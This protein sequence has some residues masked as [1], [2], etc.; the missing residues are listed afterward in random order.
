MIWYCLGYESRIE[1][2]RLHFHCQDALCT[3]LCDHSLRLPKRRPGRPARSDMQGDRAV[4]PVCADHLSP[5]RARSRPVH[6]KP[7]RTNR[8][9]TPGVGALQIL[10]GGFA[11]CVPV[12][13]EAG[14]PASVLPLRALAGSY[15]RNFQALEN[16]VPWVSWSV[17]PSK[18]SP[19]NWR[20]R[21]SGPTSIGRK[22]PASTTWE[23]I[24]LACASSLAMKTSSG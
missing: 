1:R 7:R 13:Q 23:R 18:P 8:V 19:S 10:A 24:A 2:G 6:A 11:P 21:A 4:V 5:R 14:G 3:A 9:T 15:E 16:C 17:M 20:A 12:H 22:P